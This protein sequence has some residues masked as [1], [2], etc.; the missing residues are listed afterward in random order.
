MITV[1]CGLHKTGSSSIQLALAHARV[2]GVVVPRPGDDQ[3]DAGWRERLHRVLDGGVFSDEKLLGTPFDGYAQAPSRLDIVRAS[4]RGRPCRLVVYLRP[5]PDWLESVYL[6]GVQEGRPEGP[7][8]FWSRVRE[9][10]LLQWSGLLDLLEA[11]GGAQ[12]VLVRPYGD[13]VD[14]VADFALTC[15]VPGTVGRSEMR[16]NVS[17]SAIQA[18]VIRVLGADGHLGPA[19]CGRIRATF[20]HRLALGAPRGWSAFPEDIQREIRDHSRADWAAVSARVARSDPEAGARFEAL[21]GRW[22]AETRP[23]PTED[24]IRAEIVRSLRVL[25]SMGSMPLPPSLASRVATRLRR[26]TRLL[27]A[28]GV[29]G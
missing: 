26:Y 6:Q 20:Q 3:S 24:V 29:A 25:A 7:E 12:Q 10:P 5:Q 28:R 27:R 8:E 9:A 16:E 1:H 19:E 14:V 2:S 23:F 17:I 21:L 4:L 13:D 22:G 15:G 11:D 18:P